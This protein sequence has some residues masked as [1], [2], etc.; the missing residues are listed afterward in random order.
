VDFAAA[1]NGKG[2]YRSQT[3]ALVSAGLTRR[4]WSDYYARSFSPAR[5]LDAIART[6]LVGALRRLRS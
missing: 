1:L 6:R 5:I 2:R 4:T 3:D